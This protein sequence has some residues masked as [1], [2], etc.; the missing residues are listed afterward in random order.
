MKVFNG[1]VFGLLVCTMMN[2]MGEEPD[3][4]SSDSGK[5]AEL[6]QQRVVVAGSSRSDKHQTRDLIEI[7][8]EICNERK[9]APSKS[10]NQDDQ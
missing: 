1:M 5:V 10:K 7:D 9:G 6:Q 2:A 3:Q 4:D 8:K